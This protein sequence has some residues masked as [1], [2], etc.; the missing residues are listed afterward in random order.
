MVRRRSFPAV[1]L[2]LLA[3]WALV[4]VVPCFAGDPYAYFD[5]DVSFITAAPLG[6]KQQVIGIDGQFPGPVVNVTTNWN[7][8]VNS[9]E[10]CNSTT[11]VSVWVKEWHPTA[12]ELMARWGAGHKLPHPIGLELDQVKD[13]IGSFF[14]FPSVDFQR[15]AGGYG[16]FIINSRDVIAVPFDKPHGD[17]TLF[18][19][20][21]YNKDYK[22]RRLKPSRRLHQKQRKTPTKQ[23][24][25]F[26]TL[27]SN[28]VVS[29]ST[30]PK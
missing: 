13:Q 15:A 26:R 27:L 5:W 8:L 24:C 12:E 11:M 28:M 16:G 4:M 6:V 7:V 1:A 3:V 20:D 22:A 21:W 14:Y 9:V 25:Q 2:P 30:K 10:E 23:S 17:I 19:G 29:R 18:I